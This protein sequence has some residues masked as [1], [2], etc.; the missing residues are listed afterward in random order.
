MKLKNL[1]IAVLLM[2]VL[3]ISCGKKDKEKEKNNKYNEY[4]KFYNDLK[5]GKMS[6]FYNTYIEN[7]SDNNL[8]FKEPDEGKISGII[9]LD[10]EVEYFSKRIEE[11]EKIVA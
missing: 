8:N 3:I 4:I 9:P 10:K 6:K 11:M 7:F 1:L 5:T 2:T